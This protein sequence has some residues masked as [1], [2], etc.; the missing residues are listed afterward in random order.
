M[1]SQLAWIMV[2]YL[3]PLFCLSNNMNGA[4]AVNWFKLNQNTVLDVYYIKQTEGIQ[5]LNKRC[6][7]EGSLI[8]CI[9]LYHSNIEGRYIWGKLFILK[10]AMAQCIGC[11]CIISSTEAFYACRFRE[12]HNFL[13]N[14][15]IKF[16]ILLM[17]RYKF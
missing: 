12:M 6:L 16:N 17:Y 9:R 1:W 4:L 11:W 14:W 13:K 2:R 10:A 3:G 15:N 5:P 7:I 8:E